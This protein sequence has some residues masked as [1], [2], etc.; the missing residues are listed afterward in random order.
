MVLNELIGDV[1]YTP[2]VDPTQILSMLRHC[3]LQ[4][5]HTPSMNLLVMNTAVSHEEQ[6][7][8]IFINFDFVLPTSKS[9]AVLHRK[10]STN[11]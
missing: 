1:I 9:V 2:L 6:I 11:I 3:E 7:M 8:I 5:Y 10:N 4:S